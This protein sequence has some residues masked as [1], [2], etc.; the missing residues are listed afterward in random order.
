LH[1]RWRKVESERTHAVNDILVR[2]GVEALFRC[3]IVR[4]TAFLVTLPDVW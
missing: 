3:K 1:Y 4:E 2:A